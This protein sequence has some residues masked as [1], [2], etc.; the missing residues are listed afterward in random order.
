VLY[1]I[2]FPVKG[3]L[4]AFEPRP[5]TPSAVIPRAR[6]LQDQVR[7]IISEVQSENS[8]VIGPLIPIRFLARIPRNNYP[9]ASAFYCHTS[10]GCNESYDGEK[11]SNTKQYYDK[12]LTQLYES[13][14]V[15]QTGFRSIAVEVMHPAVN[16]PPADG[17]NCHGST[18]DVDFRADPEQEIAKEDGDD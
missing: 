9:E 15:Y 16:V 17:S 10:L 2:L 3:F 1:A 5:W 14:A 8:F 4:S 11:A 12:L 18:S 6:K 7:S 13:L